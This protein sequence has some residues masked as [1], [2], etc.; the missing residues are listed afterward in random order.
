MRYLYFSFLIIFLSIITISCT[1]DPC[2]SLDCQ[3]GGVCIDGDCQCPEDFFGNECEFKLDPCTIQQCSD[4]GTDEC[5][6]TASGDAFCRCGDGFSGERCEDLWTEAYPAS[7]NAQEDCEGTF[8][9]FPVEVEPG[10]DF[11]QITLGNFHNQRNSSDPSKIVANLLS[12][13]V[14]DIYPQFMVFGRVT[15]GGS[16]TNDEGLTLLYTI[17]DG[18]DTLNCSAQLSRL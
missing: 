17:I 1:S 13:R 7:Y 6:E 14:F 18:T 10:P 12:R 15:G 16:L 2:E 4:A 11:N 5:V 3:N 8:A 9:T